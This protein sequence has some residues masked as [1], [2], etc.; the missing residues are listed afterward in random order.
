MNIYN[1]SKFSYILCFIRE[2]FM[3][4]I[5]FLPGLGCNHRE[6]EAQ[7]HAL[8]PIASCKAIVCN[9]HPQ[10]NKLVEDVLA[11]TPETFIL[12]GHSF[13]GWVAQWIA[14]TAPERVES[15]VLLGTATGK[16]TN[17]LKKIFTDM[18]DAFQ[19]HN[20]AAFF[21]KIYPHSVFEK[22]LSNPEIKAMTQKM[23]EAFSHQELYT[24]PSLEKS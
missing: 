8:A 22:N 7:I 5:I 16:L 3:K 4:T 23:Q 19:N 6:F 12:V 11:Q 21:E 20:A 9:Q 2:N 14:I 24:A 13:G 15:L 18:R 1:I 17:D 10:M